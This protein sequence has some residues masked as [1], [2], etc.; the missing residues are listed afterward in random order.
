MYCHPYTHEPLRR[1]GDFLVGDRS[2]A[3]FPIEDGM[4]VFLSERDLEGLNGRYERLYNRIAPIYDFTLRLGYVFMGRG[5]ERQARWEYLKELEIKDGDRVLE[6]SIG[7]GGN[8]KFLPR[9]ARYWGLDISRGMLKVCRREV[10]RLGVQAELCLAAAE[11]LPYPDGFFDCVYHMG[12]INFFSDKAG[13]IREMVR[14]AKP[15]T[16]ILIADET[17]DLAK[18]AVKVPVAS[19]FYKQPE[20]AFNAPVS[21]LPPG[22]QEVKVEVI[23]R[24]RLYCLTF[25]KPA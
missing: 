11:H 3:R 18:S 20:E 2:G 19:A 17:A 13:A 24:G 23:G 5:G 4:P 12:G 10:R 6:T 14:V 1:E 9:G 16:K 15:G 8:L 22:M 25:R 21:L 7:T